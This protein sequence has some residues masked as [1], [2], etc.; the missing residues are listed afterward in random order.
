MNK[1]VFCKN[2]IAFTDFILLFLSLSI[3]LFLLHLWGGDVYDYLPSEQINDRIFIHLLLSALCVVWF[4]IRLRH[5]TYRKPFWFELKEI[6]RT[7]LIFSVIELA[8]LAFSK[9]YSSRYL[10]ISTWAIALVIVPWGRIFVKIYLIKLGLYLKN[11]IIIGGGRNAI[12]AY[13]ALISEPYLGFKVKCFIS[14][15]KNPRLEELGI[16][17][18]NDVK[19]GIWE[20]ITKKSDQFIIALEDSETQ[21]RDF[22]LRYLSKK[23]YR[24]VSVI[25]TVRGLPLY[26][27]DMSFLFSYDVILLRMNN[28]LAKRTSRFLKRTMDIVLSFGLILILFPIF[29]ILYLLIYID[30]GKP[31]YKHPRIGRDGKLF[32]CFKFRSMVLDSEEILSELLKQDPECKSEWEKEFKLKNDPRVTKI[33]SFIRRTSLDELPQLFNVLIGQMSLVGPRPITEK[34]LEFYENNVDYYL[35][36]KPGITG[37]WQVSGRNDIDY[38]TRVYFDSWYVKNWSL[39]NDIAILFKTIRVVVKKNGAY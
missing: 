7:L 39:W 32:N 21:E 26:S 16:P 14:Y 22:W 2:I 10:W 17:I 1:Q 28:N 18:L 8:V 35:M 12:D 23:H 15:N 4:W 20:L 13:N 30:G 11:T 33:G 6:L 34:E 38:E 3:A 37:L 31:I 19:Q 25:P 9:L 29:L 36:A 24:S 27:T 5:Y